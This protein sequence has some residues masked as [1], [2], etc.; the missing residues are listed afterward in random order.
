MN[1]K[2]ENLEIELRTELGPGDVEAIVRFHCEEYGREFGFDPTFQDHV[3]EPLAAFA[4]SSSA[5]Q[6]VWI[7]ES[8]RAMVGCIAIVEA[9]ARAAQ[10]RWFL[11]DASARNTGLGRRLLGEAIRF[12]REIEYDALFLWT[13]SVLHAAAHLYRDFGFEI[14]ESNPGRLWGVDL[15]EERYELKLN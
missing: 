13:V 12:S 4:R 11:V 14:V 10:L 3:S 6:R 5:R 8:S 2:R 15:I 1:S 9:S 7:A